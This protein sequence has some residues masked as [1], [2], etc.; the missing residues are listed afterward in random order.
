M[1]SLCSE[2]VAFFFHLGPPQQIRNEAESYCIQYS[3]SG[4]SP[5]NLT[6]CS[7]KPD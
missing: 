6:T 4:M 3:A 7:E 2:T 5:F 1:M